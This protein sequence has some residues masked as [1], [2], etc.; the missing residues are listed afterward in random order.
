MPSPGRPFGVNDDGAMLSGPV[1]E[2]L[3][4]CTALHGA[5][6][7]Q[8]PPDIPRVELSSEM[9]RTTTP[10]HETAVASGEDDEEEIGLSPEMIA[11]VLKGCAQHDISS[12]VGVG[13]ALEQ[14]SD[15]IAEGRG[16]DAGVPTGRVGAEDDEP[17]DDEIERVMEHI[18][19][20][21]EAASRLLERLQADDLPPGLRGT[22]EGER[23]AE[24]LDGLDRHSIS[25]RLEAADAVG[26]AVELMR[27]RGGLD[28]GTGPRMA[29]RRGMEA[30][31][32]GA[33]EPAG[34]GLP[35]PAGA[36]HQPGSLIPGE[37]HRPVG[38]TDRMPKMKEVPFHK[39]IGVKK[40]HLP[41]TI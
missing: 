34:T 24:Y 31:H 35:R 10:P 16:G 30:W 40:R 27:P 36:L 17:P 19:R 37:R 25:D 1:A 23:L 2:R 28:P 5:A 9:P 14:L 3:A 20:S 7:D 29:E 18:V 41:R 26:E 38:A 39:L 32:P 15:R 4:R 11:R 6:Y 22:R 12:D 21:P 33:G 13:E 8:M